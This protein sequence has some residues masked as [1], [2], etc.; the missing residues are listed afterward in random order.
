PRSGPRTP[1]P[2][3]TPGGAGGSA[4]PHRAARH[5]HGPSAPQS[6]LLSATARTV[7]SG[8]PGNPAIV[9]GPVALAGPEQDPVEVLA[10][11]AEGGTDVVF[12]L[13]VEVLAP[14]DP[15][16]AVGRQ[17]DQPRPNDL[18]PPAQQQTLRRARGVA[19][20]DRRRRIHVRFVAGGAPARMLDD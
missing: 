18:G 12:I 7:V 13:L 6:Y 19:G 3:P 20:H 9:L 14:Q 11:H 15:P 2:H 1:A 17:F 8:Q 10:R 4:P 16:T 5:I